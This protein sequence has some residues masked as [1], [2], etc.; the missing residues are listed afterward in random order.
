[1]AKGEIVRNWT[2]VL[3]VSIASLKVNIT[4][5]EGETPVAALSGTVETMVGWAWTC[6]TA[7]PS[8]RAKWGNE[9]EMVDLE[10]ICIKDYARDRSAQVNKGQ[11]IALT[12]P[13]RPRS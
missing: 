1:M 6:P 10:R 2:E 4:A 13:S 9:L 11:V 5:V 12:R 3:A 7:R 8:A